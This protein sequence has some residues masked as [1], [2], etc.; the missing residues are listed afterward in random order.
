MAMQERERLEQAY[1]FTAR[2]FCFRRVV[3]ETAFSHWRHQ[4][5]RPIDEF[6]VVK[7]G[8]ELPGQLPQRVASIGDG[9]PVLTI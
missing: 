4:R 9:S 8:D 2:E 1:G 6:P 3:A 7:P 5:V